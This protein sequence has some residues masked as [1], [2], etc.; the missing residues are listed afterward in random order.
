MMSSSYVSFLDP[1]G[2]PDRGVDHLG[3]R[4]A[5]EAAYSKLIDFITTVAWRPRY[6]TFLCWALK[7]AWDVSA[8]KSKDGDFKVNKTLQRSILKKLDYTVAASTLVLD[9]DAQRIAGSISINKAINKSDQSIMVREDHLQNSRGSY[10]IYVGSMRGLG[11]VETASNV[12]R[13]SRSGKKL[14]QIYSESLG[15]NEKLLMSAAEK[16]RTFSIDE[17]CLIGQKASLS[18]F[19]EVTM[20]DSLETERLALRKMLFGPTA[21]LGRRLSVGLIL[22]AHI[23]MGGPVN[24]D[25]FRSLIL[26]NGIRASEGNISF[27]LPE[28]YQSILPQWATYQAHAF[29]TYALE[30]LLGIVLDRAAALESHKGEG[31]DLGELLDSIIN[32]MTIENN[33]LFEPP[34]NMK[35]WW[36]LN[37]SSLRAL[38]LQQVER[39][40]NAEFAEPDLYSLLNN[41]VPSARLSFLFFMFSIVRLEKLL[42]KYGPAAWLGSQD[43]FRLPPQIFIEDFR[44]SAQKAQNVVDYARNII[45]RYVIRQHHQNAMRKLAAIPKLDTSRFSWE[46]N[47]LVPNGSHRAGTSNPRFENAVFCLTDLGY[48]SIKGEVSTEGH[49]LLKEIEGESS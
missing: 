20:S 2:H 5:G 43:P 37:V 4:V 16:Q 6:F 27:E 26:I 29:A 38:I 34:A 30:S 48:L 21:P 41:G 14:S 42:R 10:D 1:Y 3:M 46:G 22:H 18:A 40:F 32:E 11:M 33:T 45:L 35:S 13:P 39:N 28:N 19:T 49:L 9:G 44:E 23:L 15:P 36:Q 8:E 25:Q 24:L 17:L 47:R 7:Q 12:D 31:V